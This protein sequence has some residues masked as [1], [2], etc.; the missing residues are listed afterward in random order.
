MKDLNW[1][2]SWFNT[3]Y[4]HILYQH[5]SNSE[6]EMFIGNL[7][8]FMQLPKDS[9]LLD[10]ACGKG[11]H[12]LTLSQHGYRVL[13]V[14]LS[15]QS[16][17]HATQ[18]SNDKLQF[19]I[20][21]MRQVIPDQQ[22]HAIFNL[23]TSFGYFNAWEDNQHMLHSVSSMLLPQ[24]W[25]LIDFMNAKKVVADLVEQET[26]QIEGI[27]FRIRRTTD[28]HYIFKH[29]EFEDNQQLHHYTERVQL[30]ELHDFEQLFRSTNL[31]LVHTFGD[32]HLND[33]NAQS[34]NRLILLTR[35]H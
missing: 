20:H 18:F 9:Y 7:V 31:E 16:I 13:G 29:I 15:E 22:F 25:L 21:D 3:H 24:G 1:F 28:G 32:Y 8:D 33:F 30:L 35:K 14:D 12:A 6:A 23:F 26:K 2:A 27:I 11:R 4:Y 17:A 5:R 10:L 34:S 19:R